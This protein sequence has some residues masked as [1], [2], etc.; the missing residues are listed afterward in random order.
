MIARVAAALLLGLTS[1]AVAQGRLDVLIRGGSVYDGTGGAPRIADVG[2]RGDRIV[3]V[4]TAP[5]GT[6]ALRTIDAK[7][8]VV[9]P[10]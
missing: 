8:F 2:I 6:A 1:A 4:G 5:P 3:F 10:G 9:A 7:G